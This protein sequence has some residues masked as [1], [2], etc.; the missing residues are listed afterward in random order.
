MMRCLFRANLFVTNTM[1]VLALNYNRQ[2]YLR[3]NELLNVSVRVLMYL[4][5]R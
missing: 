2:G 3:E 1:I 4:F 5:M